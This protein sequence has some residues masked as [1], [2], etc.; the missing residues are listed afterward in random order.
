MC[1]QPGIEFLFYQWA[2]RAFDTV[3]KLGAFRN[4]WRAEQMCEA[5]IFKALCNLSNAHQF[6]H[7][8][9]VGAFIQTATGV[10]GIFPF[11]HAR[12]HFAAVEVIHHEVL[13]HTQHHFIH[14]DVDA[15][16]FAGFTHF[17]QCCQR[18]RGGSQARKVIGGIREGRHWL[19]NITV[20]NQVTTEGLG[21]SVIGRKIGVLLGA[22]LTKTG[23]VSDNQFWVV[24]P[25]D[26]IGNATTGKGRTFTGFDEDIGGFH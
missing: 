19:V 20:L 18:R 11:G 14:G 7:D 2:V 26:F 1:R 17:M 23:Q 6:H 9:A 3:D 13:A 25:Q 12:A 24:L 10:V 5:N 15:F 4:F 22:I 8:V 16:A 21:D